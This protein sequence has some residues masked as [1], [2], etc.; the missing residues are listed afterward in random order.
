MLIRYVNVELVG[1]VIDSTLTYLFDSL[2]RTKYLVGRTWLKKK[3]RANERTTTNFVRKK[4][5]KGPN[6]LIETETELIYTE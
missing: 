5:M 2:A 4:E 6:K 1:F 3:K